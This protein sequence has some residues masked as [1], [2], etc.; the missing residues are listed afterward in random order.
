MGKFKLNA[1]MAK[2]VNARDLKSLGRNTLVGS[3]PILG[4]TSFM[5]EI[6][7]SEMTRDE[8]LER[9]CRLCKFVNMNI[10]QE[11]EQVDCFCNPITNTDFHFSKH[12]MI[13]IEDAITDEVDTIM[14]NRNKIQH[15]NNLLINNNKETQH[16]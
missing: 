13:F 15:H 16:G 9:L 2:L 7:M 8:I 6:S 1:E 3:S 14:E 11:H 4:T 5:K 10:F 12:V